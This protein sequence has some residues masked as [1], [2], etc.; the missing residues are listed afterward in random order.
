MKTLIFLLLLSSF[1]QALTSYPLQFGTGTESC[2][3][4]KEGLTVCETISPRVSPVVVNL[5]P[6]PENTVSYGFHVQH[7]TFE[8]IGFEVSVLI[9]HYAES[10]SDDMLTLK[11]I[12]WDLSAPYKRHEVT[13]EIFADNPKNLNRVNLVGRSIGTENDFSNIILSVQKN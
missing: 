11:V 6:V 2:H 12:T 4:N 10:H 3:P 8:K 5:E 1:A 7:G 13:S 9:A